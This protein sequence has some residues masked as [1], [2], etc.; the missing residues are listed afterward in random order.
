[1]AGGVALN[2]VANGKVLRETDFEEIFIQPAASDDGTSLGS[3]LYLWTCVLGGSR[4]QPMRDAYFGP[5]YSAEYCRNAVEK[6]GLSYEADDVT[7]KAA[8]LLADGKIVGLYQGRAEF[9]PR[10][11]GNR[12]ILTDPR[13]CEMKDVLNARVKKRES[14]RPFAP[15]VLA[16]R[17]HEYFDGGHSSPY[18]LLVEGVRPDKRRELEAI[19]H[20]DGTARVQDVER[21]VNPRYYDVIAEFGRL[22]GTPVLL[23]TSFNV[24]G[25]PIINTPEEAIW[26]FQNMDM[27]AVI[28]EDVLVSRVKDT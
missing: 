14:F 19:T 28:I 22:T 7:S 6:A 17:R 5:G 26:G 2:S 18:M 23:N 1:M 24:R 4:P 27:D 20:V 3:A 25:E 21:E 15:A 11:L 8:R 9:G 13:R 10:A 16:E 12:S